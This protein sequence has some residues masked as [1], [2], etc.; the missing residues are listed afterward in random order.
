MPD[1]PANQIIRADGTSEEFLPADGMH[2]TLEELQTAVGGTIER[3][4]LPHGRY[5]LANEDAQLIHLPINQNASTLYD[6]ILLGDVVVCEPKYF[7]DPAEE[8]DQV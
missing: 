2:F 1:E 7:D 6:Y 8:D 4:F 5:M 3:Y